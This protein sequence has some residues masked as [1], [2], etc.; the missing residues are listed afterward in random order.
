MHSLLA[1]ASRI[2]PGAPPGRHWLEG[3]D[4]VVPG[5]AVTRWLLLAD[6]ALLLLVAARRHR[7]LIAA[8][9]VLAAAFVA[10]N[11]VG[12]LVTDFFLGLAAFHVLT[13]FVG[14][15]A[16]G[17]ARWAGA[18]LLAFTLVLGALT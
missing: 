1:A 7:P 2:P 8:A 15:L 18:G 13:A 3:L 16:G 9:V 6:T 5:P 4:W 14:L 12:M 11:A 17:H 10:L